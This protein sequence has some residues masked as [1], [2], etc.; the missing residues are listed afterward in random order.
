[1]VHKFKFSKLK[2]FLFINGERGISLLNYLKKKV[3]GIIIIAIEKKKIY[4][5][6]TKTKT[7]TKIFKNI[8]SKVFKSF[9]L[10]EKPDL[11]LP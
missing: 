9:A 8:N 5:I 1:M 4:K 3:R 7:K 11:S 2:I 6:K 10:K